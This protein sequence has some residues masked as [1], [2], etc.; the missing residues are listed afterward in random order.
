MQY[1]HPEIK[2]SNNPPP[3]AR[4]MAAAFRAGD[5]VG[6][7]V[8]CGVVEGCISVSAVEIINRLVV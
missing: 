3:A 8:L 6:S 5:W 2:K 1:M 4:P 7:G